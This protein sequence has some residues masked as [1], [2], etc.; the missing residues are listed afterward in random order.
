MDE[1]RLRYGVNPHQSQARAFVTEGSLPFQVLAG[2]P[3]YINLLDAFNS[4]QLVRELAELTGLCAAA[5]FKHTSPVGAA[6]GRPLSEELAQ[7]Y[8]VRGMDLSPLACAYAR[9]RGADR[10]SSFGDWAAFSEPVDEPT[11]RVLAKEVSDGCVA[12]GYE[13][14][15]LEILKGKKSSN[16]PVIRMDPDYEP[17]PTELRQVFGVSLEQDRNTARISAALLDKVVTHKKTIPDSARTDML[18]AT[19][20]LKYTQSNSVCLAYD[21]QVIGSGAGQQSRIHCTR[22]A[23]AKADGWLLR[24]HPRVRGLQFKKD[25]TRVQKSNAVDLFLED[26]ATEEELAAWRLNFASVPERLTGQ[27]K[28]DW[29]DKFKDVALSSDAFIPF[30]DNI[31]R[32]ARSGVGYV[33]QTGGSSRDEGVIRAADEYG[34][35]MVLTGLRLFH[36]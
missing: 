4:W 5:S 29:L 34:M 13:P 12:P 36:H 27:E 30:R 2:Q 10:M 24:L 20:T 7:S 11:A 15:A 17:G 23:C 3:G 8:L 33:V 19:L 35:V 26:D 25:T 14:A 1:L 18:I 6:I 28:R 9:A 16:Y 21:G 31:D 22:V 32:A